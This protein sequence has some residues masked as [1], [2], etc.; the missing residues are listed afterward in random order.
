MRPGW[1]CLIA[2]VLAFVVLGAG[3]RGSAFAR[4]E[5][6]VT[7]GRVVDGDTLE[8]RDGTRVRLIGINTPELAHPQGGDECY[9]K[10]A[11]AFAEKLLR[12]GARLRLVLDVE[13]HD[14]YKRLLAYVYRASDGLFVNAELARRGYAFV[15]TVPPNVEHA[16]LFL[17]LT[18]QAREHERGL[19]SSCPTEHGK[20]KSLVDTCLP[21]YRG[22]CVPPPPP[23]LDCKDLPGPVT[24]KGDDPHRLDSDG[25]GVACA[26]SGSEGS[27]K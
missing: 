24:V 6:T 4:S 11:T 8:L 9:G 26:S 5:R 7:L 16:D 14:R 23:D 22:A 10:Q 15:E 12:P 27:A 25:D 20:P 3:T 18:R 19:W 2:A 13:T 17:R 21:Q 1:R